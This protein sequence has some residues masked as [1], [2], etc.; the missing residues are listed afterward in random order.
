MKTQRSP[1]CY[2]LGNLSVCKRDA[3]PA[4][5]WKMTSKQDSE[6]SY[7]Y[8]PED[9]PQKAIRPAQKR[10]WEYPDRQGKPLVRVVRIDDGKGSKPKRWQEHWN[11]REWIKGL[12]GIKRVNI[13]IYRYRE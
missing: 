2:F 9:K 13:P 6:G 1:G 4:P 7:Y 5:S 11:G 12:K 10:T 8:A 3:E